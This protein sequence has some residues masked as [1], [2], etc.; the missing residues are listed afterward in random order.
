MTEITI[1][2]I[3]IKK[4]E[5]ES[6]N[7]MVNTESSDIGVDLITCVEMKWYFILDI[8]FTIIENIGVIKNRCAFLL[9]LCFHHISWN[10]DTDRDHAT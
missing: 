5:R 10:F 3:E 1:K 2:R 7:A 4:K 8:K 6:K 9:P